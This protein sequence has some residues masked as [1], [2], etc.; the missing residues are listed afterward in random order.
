MT[1]YSGGNIY[2]FVRL[3]QSIT[4][5]PMWLRVA[6][7]LLFWFVAVAMFLSFGLRDAQLPPSIMQ[8]L[9]WIGTTW[10][11]FLLYMVLAL[12]IMDLT[13]LFL[14][15][16]HHGFWYALLATTI[17]L[18]YGNIN[19]RHPRVERV[20]ISSDK[21][22]AKDSY[23]VI[24][25]SDIHLGYGTTRRDLS[26]YVDMI[27]RERG[28]VVIIAGDLI[29]NSVIPVAQSDMCREF[30]RVEARDGIYLAPGNHE[31]ISNIAAVK[32]YLT[33]T[34]VRLVQDSVVPL[35]SN[36]TLIAR[37][38]RSNRHRKSLEELVAK[39][40]CTTLTIVV[41]HQPYDIALSDSL[42]VDIHLSGHTHRGQVW[43]LSWITDS[44]YEQSHG[45]RRWR[46]TYAIVSC[47]LSLW[48]PPFRIG[49]HSDLY[50]IDI[51]G[52]EMSGE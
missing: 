12:G 26:R 45:Y 37:D 13:R 9:F 22:P 46:H 24:L 8:S 21:L 34:P 50:V 7:A 51:C 32:E 38:D 27:N 49:T 25:A 19:Y 41:D 36:I 39:A 44:I 52:A 42:G 3:W 29:D 16:L 2:L 43:P 5:L 11:V 31:Y 10:L 17:L 28:D 1:L 20:T 47:G 23:R 4:M 15:S 40:G 48:G 33:T 30:S 14:P 35:R 6:I 18:I